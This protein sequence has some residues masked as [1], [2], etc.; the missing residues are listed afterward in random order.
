MTFLQGVEMTQIKSLHLSSVWDKETEKQLLQY[1]VT[2]IHYGNIQNTT[3]WEGGQ[4][5]VFQIKCG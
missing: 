3:A 4:T 1:D 2:H 5:K